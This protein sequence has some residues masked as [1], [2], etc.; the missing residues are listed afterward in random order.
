MLLFRVYRDAQF[1][2]VLG[3]WHKIQLFI[4]QAMQVLLEKVVFVGQ[5]HAPLTATNGLMHWLQKLV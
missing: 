1:V 4:G 5:T 3:V 2:H